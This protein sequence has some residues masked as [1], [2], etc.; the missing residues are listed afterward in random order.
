ME[1]L[2]DYVGQELTWEAQYLPPYAS[3]IFDDD[4]GIG[5]PSIPV[6]DDEK[7][8]EQFL[9]L[10]ERME[11]VLLVSDNARSRCAG[12]GIIDE[13]LPQGIWCGFRVPHNFFVVV[14]ITKVNTEYNGQTAY[15][16]EETI[17]TLDITINRRVLWSRYKVRLTEPQ[18]P[19]FGADVKEK[20][21][22]GP[23]I[24]FQ[25]DKVKN[26]FSGS[27]IKATDCKEAEVV[28]HGVGAE[29][30]VDKGDTE[31]VSAYLDRPL[32]RGRICDLLNDDLSVLGKTKIVVYFPNE[33]FDEEN[34]GDT[35]AGVLF[36]SDGDLQMTLFH[37][38]LAQVQLEEGRLLSEI[39]TWCSEHGES[40]GDNSG[41]ERARKNP[42][43][44]M[45]RWKLS[46]P[47]ETKLKWKLL[48]SDVQKVNSLRCC[49]F[50]CCQ[51]FS[52]EDMLAFRHKFYGST[53]EV[54]REIAY[55]V[56]VG[57]TKCIGTPESLS[58]DH[59]RF[60]LRPIL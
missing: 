3:T 16:K 54:R 18:G 32:W 27:D 29:E 43:R 2:S 51:T 12:L 40:S 47:V 4:C 46:P 50:K 19:P 44:H 15:C 33:P 59:I 20:G 56:P 38:P 24:R 28:G 55:A 30:K 21:I 53:F 31:F 7:P 39:V 13:C 17:T 60:R 8:I 11:V 57:S 1:L 35:D 37:W 25:P 45:K 48:D 6:F 42:Y 9:T 58:C 23:P 5:G 10:K 34:L 26:K 36:L 49:K 41:L 22:G 52:W 14:N